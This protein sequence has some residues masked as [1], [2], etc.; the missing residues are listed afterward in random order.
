MH[1]QRRAPIRWDST[2]QIIIREC[3]ATLLFALF[4]IYLPSYALIQR[5]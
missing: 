3:L 2:L 5:T 1:S 4:E